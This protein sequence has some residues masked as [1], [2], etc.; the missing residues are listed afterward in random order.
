MATAGSWR[1]A[2][3]GAAVAG[4]CAPP[5]AAAPYPETEPPAGQAAAEP[6]PEP[7]PAPEPVVGIAR[8]FDR[9]VDLAPFLA[10]FP[11][12]DFHPDLEHG[13]TYYVDKSDDYR[14]RVLSL[15]V[16]GAWELGS[17]EPVS[18]VDWS[19]RSLWDVHWHAPT[20]R[21]WLHADAKNDEQMNLWA[22]D[23]KTGALEQLTTHDYVYSMGF[24]EDES[25]V[26]Y[27]PRSGK[28]APFS[29]CLRLRDVA[30][31]DER[32]IV[33]D[34]PDLRFTW[35][36]LR[37]SPDESALYFSAQVQGDRN[38]V[39]LVRVDLKAKAPKVE[40]LT[41]PK[42]PR[43]TPDL[44][45][46]WI[47]GG[48]RL[49]FLSN[50]DGYANLWSVSRRTGKVQQLTRYREDI[51]SAELAG[52]E[53]I[54][55]HR[56]PAG[57]TLV[58]L[59]AKTGTELA[60]ERLP[61][62]ADV[63][64]AH[65][66]RALVT[67]Q[68]P[69]IVHQQLLVDLSQPGL[70]LRPVVGLGEDLES[71]IVACKATAVQIPTFDRD[72]KTRS[73]RMLHAFL[74]EPAQ[75]PSDDSTR[76]GLVT[77]FYGGD[78]RYSTFDHVMCAA[79][80]TV[81]SP[82]VRGSSGFGREFQALNDRDLGG[83]EIVDLFHVARW[84][85]ERTGLPAM[86]I[87][88]YGGSHGGFATMRALT[89]DP[90]TNGRNESYAFGFGMAHA[91]F[92]DIKSFYDA[93]NIPDWVVLESGDPNVPA[94]LAKMQQRSPRLQVERL[95][96]PLLLTHGS[97]D[98]RVPVEESRR[99]ADAAKALGRPVQYVEFEGQGHH[100]EGLKLQVQLYQTRFDFLRAVA[101][102]VTEAERAAGSGRDSDK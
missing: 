92:S 20:G 73:K 88:V 42:R 67:Q 64:D 9:E 101:E 71:E 45:E 21:L 13:R 7:A 80:L 16:A 97:A 100:I 76:L 82:A 27:L 6:E 47:D 15:P 83:D 31:G 11:Y 87:G 30:T 35:S 38:R 1:A 2:A 89:F 56:S 43:N 25:T 96:A 61:G 26:A 24:S 54:A 74:L 59:D 46:G 78:N 62:S 94:D 40:V 79:G 17:G 57:S 66:D 10:G 41:D 68:S 32:E 65:G 14:L 95:Q 81:V 70:R 77:A 36:S 19:G 23:P 86:R 39:Q 22:L 69:D 3:F 33:C 50:E 4:A 60:A 34:S 84:L 63:A 48:D 51:T 52:G 99:F 98:W 8:Y 37:F 102:A 90:K 85:E 93:T 44:L 29:T 28:Q 72:K 12:A 58:R 75:P 91:G 5:N 18:D 49:L 55:V 53:V